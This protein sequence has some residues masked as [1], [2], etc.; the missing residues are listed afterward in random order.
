MP[1]KTKMYENINKALFDYK[2]IVIDK[3][4]VW[5]ER[6]FMANSVAQ[7]CIQKIEKGEFSQ[8]QIESFGKILFL[9]LRNKIDLYWKDDMLHVHTKMRKQLGLKNDKTKVH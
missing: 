8:K 3:K 2:L 9:Y 1:A 5:A 7:W 4:M 6:A